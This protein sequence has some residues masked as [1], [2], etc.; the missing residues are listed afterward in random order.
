M[1]VVTPPRSA[2]PID[3]VPPSDRWHASHGWPRWLPIVLGA[4]LFFTSFIW[5]HAGDDLN[6]TWLVGVLMAGFGVV[7]LYRPGWR[8]ATAVLGLWLA[9]ST[10]AI[11]HIE[12]ATLWNNVLVG[13]A[14]FVASLV[15]DHERDQRMTRRNTL[16]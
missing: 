7:A 3:L 5:P 10:Q 4:W 8:W 15:R 9:I 12:T 14:V 13:L 1:G 16:R 11:P 2:P 6:N